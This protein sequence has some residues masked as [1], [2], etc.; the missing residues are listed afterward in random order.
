VRERQ[1]ERREIPASLFSLV[2]ALL[3]CVKRKNFYFPD[4]EKSQFLK[5]GL[6]DFRKFWC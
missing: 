5:L 6:F 3:I 2:L 4:R 1:R